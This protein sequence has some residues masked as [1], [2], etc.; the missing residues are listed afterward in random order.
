MP[1]VRRLGVLATLGALALSPA[2]AH[3]DVQHVVARGHTLLSIAHRYHVPVKAILEANHLKDATHLK[4]GSTLTIPGATP[5]S[6][7][8]GKVEA[9]SKKG[10]P[11]TYK[12]RPKTPGVVH[13]TRLATNEDFTVRVAR[14]G[15][16]S[17]TALSS[18]ERMMRNGAG[19][20]HPIDPHLIAL[21]GTVSDHFGSRRST[22]TTRTTTSGTPSI[23][24]WW[25]SPTR[26]CATIAARCTTSESATTPTAP[27]CT[28]TYGRARRS[29]STTRAL[30]SPRSTTRRT[31]TPTRERA[32]SRTTGIRPSPPSRPTCL[33]RRPSPARRRC[34]LS[35]A[36]SPAH[37]LP[38]CSRRQVPGRIPGQIRR[39]PQSLR[40]FRHRPL[41]P[42][43]PRPPR[44]RR[45]RA[46]PCLAPPLPIRP[47][48]ARFPRRSDPRTAGTLSPF[49]AESS[50]RFRQG[51][52]I[53]RDNAVSCRPH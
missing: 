28:S 45:P 48:Q 36:T 3:A 40:R 52:K 51:A 50:R 18:F 16:A 44:L 53:R 24:A 31:S 23:S 17:P 35:G 30:A 29:G 43:P 8:K 22:R 2:L 49:V 20:T 32:T 26:C 33:P 39:K 27:S 38:L 25:V 10:L 46:R 12:L 41:P 13:A 1:L 5:P 15:H 21:V 11:G 14:R 19:L 37:H 4:V 42:R 6:A 7:A 9:E 34:R 47:R